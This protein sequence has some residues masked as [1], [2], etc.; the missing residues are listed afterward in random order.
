LKD[1]LVKAG[2]WLWYSKELL[3]MLIMIGVLVYR[4][5]GVFSPPP[6]PKWP[7]LTQPKT[8]LPTTPEE[9]EAMALPGNPQ[10]RPPLDVPSPG[11][12]STLYARNPFWYHSGKQKQDEK[13]EITAADLNI[14]LLD[15]QDTGGKL[16]ARLRTKVT[17]KWYSENEQFE[18]FQLLSID[19][20]SQKVEI[21]STRYGRNFTLS[22]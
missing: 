10:P 17:T 16:R 14:Q 5:Y 4:V 7:P 3:V 13:K 21:Y 9:M 6:P 2:T 15:I 19:S 22:K 18:E 20:A 12:Y 11:S 1:K 8:E